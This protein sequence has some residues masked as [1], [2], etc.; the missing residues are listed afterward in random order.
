MAGFITHITCRLTAK[1]WDQLQNPTLSN[2][3]WATFTFFISSVSVI[4]CSLPLRVWSVLQARSV[5]ISWHGTVAISA[6]ACRKRASSSTVTP[7][8]PSF[9][10]FFSARQKSRQY[11]AVLPR[12]G[13]P[14]I[15]F[16][17]LALYICIVCF[18]FNRMLPHL[19]FF[20]HFSLLISS[21]TYL[22]L[23]E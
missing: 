5:W 11:L 15:W 7:I 13:A 22:F 23:W 19:P 3:V 12:V 9:R 2:R 18:F 20:L 21:L 1:N 8:P 6:V 4:G 10:C 14:L 16:L 17:I